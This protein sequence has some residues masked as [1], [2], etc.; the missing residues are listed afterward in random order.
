MAYSISGRTREIGIRVALGATAERVS[1]MIVRDG[2]LLAFLGVAL[3][4]AL[5]AASMRLLSSFLYQSSPTD[6][7]TFAGAALL[8]L[9][10]SLAASYIPARRALEVDPR[11]ALQHE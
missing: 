6:P 10:V 4:M 9:A 2:L 5:A 3:G 11:V 8:L 1:R 7:V